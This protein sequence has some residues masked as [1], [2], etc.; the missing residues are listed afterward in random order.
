MATERSSPNPTILVGEN[1]WTHVL[2]GAIIKSNGFEGCIPSV[3]HVRHSILFPTPYFI[4][5]V[6]PETYDDFKNRVGI[7]SKAYLFVGTGSREYWNRTRL[8]RA[9]QISS[10]FTAHTHIQLVQEFTS[11]QLE[12]ANIKFYNLGRLVDETKIT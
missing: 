5:M 9:E 8:Q 2:P 6:G 10:R 12:G 4:H 1:K 7:V 3:V 11:I